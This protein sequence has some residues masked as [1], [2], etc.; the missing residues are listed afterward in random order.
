MHPNFQRLKYI[1]VTHVNKQ[2]E[3]MKFVNNSNL[4]GH[5]ASL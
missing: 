3:F 4:Q 5:F 2:I 1:F